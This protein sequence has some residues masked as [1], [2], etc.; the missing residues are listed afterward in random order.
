MDGNIQFETA[1]EARLYR[2]ELKKSKRK[3]KPLH[4]I[5]IIALVTLLKLITPQ[6]VQETGGEVIAKNSGRR[7]NI[8]IMGTDKGGLRADVLMIASVSRGQV[9]LISVPRDTRISG[10]NGYMKINSALAAGGD[11]Y[12]IEKVEGVTGID[13]HEYVK[14]DFSA[15]ENMIDAF[16][17]VDFDIPQN[18]D[19]EDPEQDLYIHLKEG[20]HHLNGEDSLKLLRFRGYAMADIERTAVQRNFIKAFITQ[21]LNW[22]LVYKIPRAGFEFIRGADSTLNIFE[23]GITGAK[24]LLAGK[25]NINTLEIPY[26]FSPGGTYVLIDETK[27]AEMAKNYFE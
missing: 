14:V 15:V 17:G 22:S 9:N 24:V 2:K 8:L 27:M 13:I 16:G 20:M 25:N 5:I 26:Y 4:I 11:E 21:N 3:I 19:Y 23:T 18:M 10:G 7:E 1:T 12:L 6:P